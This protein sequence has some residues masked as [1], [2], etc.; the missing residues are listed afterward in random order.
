MATETTSHQSSS[1][2]RVALKAAIPKISVAASRSKGSK[3]AEKDTTRCQKAIE[4]E[5]A[6]AGKVARLQ[7]WTAS[8]QGEAVI[9]H[10]FGLQQLW[11]AES[12]LQ[13]PACH[14]AWSPDGT[15][16]QGF[17]IETN[18]FD[19]SGL[20]S[21]AA[22]SLSISESGGQ[23]PAGRPRPTPAVTFTPT[24]A[25]LRPREDQEPELSEQLKL[26]IS[27]T[28]LPLSYPQSHGPQL[29]PITQGTW[30][31]SQHSFPPHA[32]SSQ[33]G[34]SYEGEDQTLTLSEDEGMALYSAFSP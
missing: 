3:V 26:L 13:Q 34:D 28:L 23:L 27:H 6:K 17:H 15:R 22:S 7:G 20:F 5:M 9:P 8:P 32:P 25:D 4:T 19:R 10:P 29:A 30:M 2:Q 14:H 1:R 33:S 24:A 31:E 18:I 11:P 12:I 21:N 16:E